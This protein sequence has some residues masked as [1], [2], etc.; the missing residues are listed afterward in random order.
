M[1]FSLGV[2]TSKANT[3]IASHLSQAHHIILNKESEDEESAEDVLAMAN[4]SGL[5][6]GN[7]VQIMTRLNVLSDTLQP[8]LPD[9]NPHVSA[10]AGVNGVDSGQPKWMWTTTNA[11][12][13]LCCDHVIDSSENE[14]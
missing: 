12:F 7:P 4:R 13:S 3:A 1:D 5:D 6:S 9:L 8:E 11:V 10:N 14:V 2:T